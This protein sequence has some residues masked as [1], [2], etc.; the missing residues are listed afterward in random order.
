M[1]L[2]SLVRNRA[3]AVGAGAVFGGGLLIAVLTGASTAL[4][5]P[6]DPEVPQTGAIV[7]QPM[8][9][10]FGTADSNGTMIAVT[11]IDITGSSILYLVDTQSKHLAVYQANGGSESSQGIKLVGARRI[12]LDLQLDGLNDKSQYSVQEL[13]R[14]FA[15]IGGAPADPSVRR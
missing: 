4:Q 12:D 6:G 7:P 9:P 14:K 1:N 3:F 2:D 11:G 8:V 5:D 10:A 13:E 15:E